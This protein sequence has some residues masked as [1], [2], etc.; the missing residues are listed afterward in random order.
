MSKHLLGPF[1]KVPIMVR[2][3]VMIWE[4]KLTISELVDKY[5][6]KSRFP[7]FLKNIEI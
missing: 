3:H 2:P 5:T 1:Y 4:E 7:T 6:A